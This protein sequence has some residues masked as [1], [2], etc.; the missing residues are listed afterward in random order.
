[1]GCFDSPGLSASLAQLRADQFQI[2]FAD[3][4]TNLG[5]PA[6]LAAISH[7]LHPDGATVFG[8]GANLY[9]HRALERAYVEAVE[10][11]VNFFNFSGKTIRPRC[12]KALAGL[13][14]SDYFQRCQF[15]FDASGGRAQQRSNPEGL[16]IR[17]EMEA[18]LGLLKQHGLR[19]YFA[20]LTPTGLARDVRYRL[21]RVFISWLQ[22][23]VYELDAWRLAN[24]RLSTAA[25]HHLN[26]LRDPFAANEFAT[27]I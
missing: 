20:D 16:T 19:L 27:W 9:P 23:H 10:L 3:L 12:V 4:T 2:R 26:L 5:I 17:S 24:P 25:S 18:C 6:Y 13:A 21:V 15:L 22:P 7:P 1:V 14:P 11:L 8:L